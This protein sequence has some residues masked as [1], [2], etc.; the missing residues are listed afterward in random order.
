MLKNFKIFKKEEKLVCGISDKASGNIDLRFGEDGKVLGNRKRLARQLGIDLETLFEMDQVH[1]SKVRVLDDQDLNKIFYCSSGSRSAK[2]AEREKLRTFQ[3]IPDEL[4][5]SSRLKSRLARR[6]NHLT[7]IISEVDALISDKP[8]IFLMVKTADC[9]PLLF[10]DPM[11]RVVAAVHVGWRGAVEK[12]FLET[13][14]IMMKKF[15]CQPVNIKVVIGPGA[16]KCCF[17]HSHYIQEKLPEWKQYILRSNRHPEPA[18]LAAGARRIPVKSLDI[19]SFITDK[20]V[21]FGVERGN[22][23][24][25]GICTICNKRFFSHFRAL[26]KGEVEGRFA[27]I[28]GLR[29]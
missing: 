4:L 10:F 6:R 22:I 14:L 15:A 19:A 8:G 17:V 20:L 26:R 7:N 29:S 12:I 16:R 13:L 24:D 28:I 18:C 2:E 1:G 11:K 21:S 27:S 23:E 3:D 5:D 25:T 9:F